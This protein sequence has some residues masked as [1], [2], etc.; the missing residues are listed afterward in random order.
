LWSPAAV[1][2][3]TLLGP[4]QIFTLTNT[5][6]V[7]VTGIA[8]ATLGLASAADYT[9]IRLLSTCGPA[10]NGQLLPQTSLNPGSSC[11]VTVQFRPLTTDSIHSVRPAT[12]QVTDSAGTQTAILNGTAN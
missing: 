9:I 8:Q 12:V 4:V 5:G 11:L 6:T 10:G 3:V 7:A 1:R 2:G